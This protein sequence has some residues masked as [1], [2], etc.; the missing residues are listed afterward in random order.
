MPSGRLTSLTPELIAEMEK[1]LPVT[2]Y[3][4]TAFDVIGIPRS[5]WRLWLQRGRKEEK[6]LARPRARP[7]PSEEIYVRFVAAFRKAMA[8]SQ[9]RALS[10]IITASKKNWTAAAWLLERRWPSR[11]SGY[12]K[13]IQECMRMNQDLEKRLQRLGV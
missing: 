11:W 13:E 12:R 6:R 5:T 10:A 8:E 7:K 1:Y 2:L 9:A 4:D 3:V